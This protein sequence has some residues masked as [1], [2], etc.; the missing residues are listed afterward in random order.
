MERVR[1]RVF[2]K[3][4]IVSLLEKTPF[5]KWGKEWSVIGRS[6]VSRKEGRSGV[7]DTENIHET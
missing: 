6:R 7:G 1:G 4:E 5:W 3:E 2:R